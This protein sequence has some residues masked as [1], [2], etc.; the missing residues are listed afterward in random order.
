M[1]GGGCMRS[2]VDTCLVAQELS[3]YIPCSTIAYWKRVAM[4]LIEKGF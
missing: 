2:T 1:D 3:R 4:T